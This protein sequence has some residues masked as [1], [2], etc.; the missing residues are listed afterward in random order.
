METHGENVKNSK[1]LIDKFG[2]NMINHAS[3]LLHANF[4]R[5]NTLSGIKLR[6]ND[7]TS[8]A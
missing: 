7:A 2:Y 8:V 3:K 1:L 4:N 6:R 5:C